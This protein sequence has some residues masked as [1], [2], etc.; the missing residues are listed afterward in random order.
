M[1]NVNIVRLLDLCQI[2]G[3]YPII[4]IF[5]YLLSILC[6]TIKLIRFKYFSGNYYDSFKA[7]YYMVFEFCEHDLAGLLLNKNVVFN[8]SEIKDLLNQI[9]NGLQYIH[10]NKVNI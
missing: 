2:R 9:L 8:L 3:T 7:I 5:S 4:H 1:R 6:W 10:V